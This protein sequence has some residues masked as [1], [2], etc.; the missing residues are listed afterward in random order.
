MIDF[1]PLHVDPK[2]ELRLLQLAD[3]GRLFDLVDENRAHMRKWLPWVDFTQTPRDSADFIEAS[4]RKI[5]KREEIHCG[6]WHDSQWVGVIGTHSIDWEKR[7]T[8]LGYWII[9]EFEGKGIITKSCRAFIQYLIEHMK[10][11]RIEICCAADNLRSC[12]VAQRL[13]F[14]R[15]GLPLLSSGRGGTSKAQVVY[16]WVAP[17]VASR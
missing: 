14:E 7:E 4:L 11:A 13:G 2:T 15:K 6:I 3:A 5:E 12:A 8:S 17:P 9:K 1:H 16:C 10:L